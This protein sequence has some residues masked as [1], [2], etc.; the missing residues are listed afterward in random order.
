M[1]EPCIFWS[2]LII[3]QLINR[4]LFFINTKIEK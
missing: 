3:N 1:V 4:K 2:L